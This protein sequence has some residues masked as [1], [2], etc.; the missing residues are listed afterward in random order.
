MMTLSS[1]TR[2]QCAPN[3]RID[4]PSRSE[5]VFTLGDQRHRFGTPALTLID[6]FQTPHTMPEVLA[7]LEGQARTG[8]EWLHITSQI[9][10]LFKAGILIDAD[11]VVRPAI[12]GEP[13]GFDSAQLHTALLN[14]QPRVNGYRQAIQAVVKPGDVVVEIGTGTGILSVMAAQAG[15]SRVYAVEATSIAEMAQQVFAANG[16]SDRITLVRGWSTRVDLPERADVLIGE[17]IGS[18]PLDENVLEFTNDALRRLLRPGARVIPERLQIL[19]LPIEIDADA[20]SHI[21]FS[22]AAVARWQAWYGVDFTPLQQAMNAQVQLQYLSVSHADFW[23]TLADPVI[24]ADFRLDQVN[25]GLA[26]DRTA[27]S[28]FHTAGHV[29]AVVLCFDL[30]LAP[31]VHLTNNPLAPNAAVSWQ[32]PT[33]VFGT[34]QPVQPG[35]AFSI[36][37]QYRAKMTHKVNLRLL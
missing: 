18:D 3:L 9:V 11:A 15:A 25:P 12:S 16:V 5:T 7:L 8:I 10:S 28:S 23:R 22:D 32:L 27:E 35:Q 34:P 24:V 36:D 29:N 6:L 33:W 30:T 17:L 19:A 37:Y 31:G 26:F 1:T 20:Y 21:V 14:D 2:L 13:W 4:I